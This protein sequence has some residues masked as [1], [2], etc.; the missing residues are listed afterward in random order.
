MKKKEDLKN[1]YIDFDCEMFSLLNDF[2][3]LLDK[4]VNHRE[5]IDYDKELFSI[6]EEYSFTIYKN[7]GKKSYDYFLRFKE[8]S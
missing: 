2:K 4:L 8:R 3:D 6:L 1:Y 5:L 7:D